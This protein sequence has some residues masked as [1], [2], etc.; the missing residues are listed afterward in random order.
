MKACLLAS[1]LIYSLAFAEETREWKVGTDQV[2]FFQDKDGSWLSSGCTD[3]CQARNALQSIRGKKPG[4]KEIHLGT[5]PVT[6][7][8]RLANGTVLVG[9]DSASNEN[10]LCR[11]KDG[12]YATCRSLALGA[13][14]KLTQLRHKK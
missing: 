10:C 11:F 13:E 6:A 14:G 8:C 5:N 9:R 7:W 4:P 3:K 1:L 12:S 2:K